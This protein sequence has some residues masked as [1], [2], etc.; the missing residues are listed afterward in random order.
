[1]RERPMGSV[2]IIDD[3]TSILS[4]FDY[5]LRRN[6]F[7]VDT[8]ADGREGLRKFLA[9]QFDLVLTDVL[10]QGMDG[11]D[12]LKRIRTSHRGWTPV[13]G[14]SG[15]PW[16]LDGAGFDHILEKPFSIYHLVTSIQGLIK[17]GLPTA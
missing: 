17:Q 14:M 16:L 4:V 7:D 9:G 6:G 11:R 13:I 8:A 12:L 3:E 2:L 1:M 5:A 10:L 15:T